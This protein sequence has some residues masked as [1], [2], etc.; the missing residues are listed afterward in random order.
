MTTILLVLLAMVTV[1]AAGFA[2]VP[3]AL[4]GGRAEKRRKA[5]QGNIRVNRMEADLVRNRDDRRKSVQQALKSQTAALNAKKRVSLS[6]LIFQAGMTIKP[7]AFIRNS[8][9]FGAAVTVLLILVQVPMFL[10]PVFGLAAG[11]LLPRFYVG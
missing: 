11:Y 1:G 3:S 9:I 2:L 10:A 4:G 8:I 5:L 7:A 6:Q